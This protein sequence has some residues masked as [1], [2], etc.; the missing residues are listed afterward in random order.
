MAA[1]PATA[2]AL[3][4][5]TWNICTWAPANPVTSRQGSYC[6]DQKLWLIAD[7][8]RQAAPS[9]V[10][11]Q[12]VGDTYDAALAQLL[13][14]DYSRVCR[15]AS[16]AGHTVL[17][18][19]PALQPRAEP[20]TPR[21]A[22]ASI[23]LA[24]AATACGLPQNAA[25]AAAAAA[26]EGSPLPAEATV[27]GGSGK[28]RAYVLGCHLIFGKDL[29]AKRVEQVEAALAS[30]PPDARLVVLLGD[31]NFWGPESSQGELMAVACTAC[32]TLLRIAARPG[33]AAQQTGAHVSRCT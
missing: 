5:L 23:P 1:L 28:Q 17:Y 26:A 30:L 6:I 11:L 10:C 9:I 25:L 15:V 31:T 12:E 33:H 8:I 32:C 29:V 19:Q 2:G 24:A 21:V 14:P 3:S 13:A 4:G 18:I 7:E 20:P 27:A 22:I 16:H